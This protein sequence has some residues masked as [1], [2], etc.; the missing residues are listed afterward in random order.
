MAELKRKALSDQQVAG[1]SFKNPGVQSKDEPAAATQPGPE[2]EPKAGLPAIIVPPPS[3][4]VWEEAVAVMNKQ[5]AIIENVGG[6]AVIASWEPSPIDLERLMVV[7]QSKE[8][9]LL[10]YSNRFVSVEVPNARGGSHSVTAPLG[11]WWLGH[12][13]R[14][15][16][17]GILGWRQTLCRQATGNDN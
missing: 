3:S 4:P 11:Q 1:A 5:H 7:F 6:K 12:R 8:S 9:F 10:R 15:Q 13:D 14:L 16:F 2:A 17:R